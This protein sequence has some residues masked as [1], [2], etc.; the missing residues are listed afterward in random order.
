M[1]NALPKRDEQLRH[2][3]R[4][5]D[6][7]RCFARWT[8]RVF[9]CVLFAIPYFATA[10][11]VADYPTHGIRLIVPYTPAGIVDIVARITATALASQLGQ[12]VVVDNRAGAGGTIGM[13]ALINAPAD[14]YT[15]GIGTTG[16]LAIMP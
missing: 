2:S 1:T 7:A 8:S 4:G 3:K 11:V 14:G 15:L 12:S 10:E 9:V 5:Y 16:P 13:K 6:C